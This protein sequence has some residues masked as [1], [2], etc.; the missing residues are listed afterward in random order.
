MKSNK[1]DQI[2]HV[3][4]ARFQESID[5]LEWLARFPHTIYNRG[6]YCSKNSLHIVDCVENV[7]REAFLFLQHIVKNYD[8]LARINIFTQAVQNVRTLYTEEDF[9]NDVIR[10]AL[11]AKNNSN[12]STILSLSN[13]GF[14]FL[15]PWC[16]S[17]RHPQH[18]KGLQ[19]QYG[20]E[21]CKIFTEGYHALLNFTVEN[22]RFS[23]TSCF[24]VTKEA[25][26]RNP[27]DY[28]IRLARTLGS[29]IN[30]VEG[31]FFERAWPQVFHST[32]SSSQEFHC[33]LDSKM[34]C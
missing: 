12:D 29:D 30:P 16:A 8:R 32:C 19:K 6:D 10:L 5:H 21:K 11:D 24:A 7:G 3:T 33:L 4:V 25:I 9:R 23:G 18:M 20:E 22:P 26:Y 13:D 17:S 1:N 15:V 2:V 14:V 27:K 28:Y 34:S 31:H